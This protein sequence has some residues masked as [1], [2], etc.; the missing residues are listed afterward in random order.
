MNASAITFPVVISVVA[1]LLVIAAAAFHIWAEYDGNLKLKYVSKPIPMVLALLIAFCVQADKP[2]YQYMIIGGLIFSL[3]GDVFLMLPSDK[4]LA[5]LGA[6]LIAHI[7]YIVAFGSEVDGFVLWPLIPLLLYGIVV[8][9]FLASSLKEVKVPVILYLLVIVAMAWLACATWF[10][11]RETPA[12]LALI[13]A[14]LFVISDSI[15]AI[16]R[17]RTP[18]RAARG[19]TLA[20]Y[21]AAQWFIAASVGFSSVFG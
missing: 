16:N 18:F 21:F 14:L 13:G 4:F 11:T 10:Q 3:A 8:Y 9:S 2:F 6:F 15:L 17:F 5:G 19:L 1:T 12:L 7:F 20:T